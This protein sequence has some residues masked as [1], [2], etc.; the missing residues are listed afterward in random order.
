MHGG[1]LANGKVSVQVRHSHG[2]ALRELVTE[3]DFQSGDV[4]TCYGGFACRAP[5]DEK[6]EHTHMRHIPSSD[7]VLNG[8]PFANTFPDDHSTT[9]R[10]GWMV[11]LKPRSGDKKWDKVISDTEIGYMANSVTSCPLSNREYPNV[12]VATGMLGRSITDVAYED[13][14]YLLASKDG[15]K[16]GETVVSPYESRQQTEKFQFKCA[17]VSHYRAAGQLPPAVTHT[18]ETNADQ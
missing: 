13:V 10:L 8:L 6:D 16:K 5:V 14:V 2:R 11:P 1:T 12:T 7:L 17:D 9:Q 3:V 18:M 4:V 15:I